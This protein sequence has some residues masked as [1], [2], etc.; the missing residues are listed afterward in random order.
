MFNYRC[1][2]KD[3]TGKIR[4]IS[5]PKAIFHCTF[6]GKK[7]YK[8]SSPNIFPVL[9]GYDSTVPDW[10]AREKERNQFGNRSAN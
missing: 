8:N 1:C 3:S 4:E 5:V 6:C 10:F 9:D 7:L 2:K